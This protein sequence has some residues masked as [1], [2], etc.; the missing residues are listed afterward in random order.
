LLTK[1]IVVPSNEIENQVISFREFQ[2]TSTLLGKM[3]VT[4]PDEVANHI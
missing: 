2:K 4:V 1:V 3:T